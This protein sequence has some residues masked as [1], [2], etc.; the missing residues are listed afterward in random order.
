MSCRL[1]N[2]N[3]RNNFQLLIDKRGNFGIIERG[4]V[5]K[6]IKIKT[7]VSSDFKSFFVSR[8]YF[9]KTQCLKVFY[10][11]SLNKELWPLSI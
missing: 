9:I 10:F 11:D 8:V 3:E 4:K 1:L 5:R 2:D 7:R 6:E